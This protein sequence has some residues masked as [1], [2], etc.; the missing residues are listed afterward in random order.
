MWRDAALVGGKDLRVELRSRVT[1]TQ[2]AP[3]A[4]LVLLL[5]GFAFDQNHK[6]LTQAAPGLFWVAVLLCTLLAV[7]RSFALE[8]A[9]GARDGLRLS[10]LDPAGIFVGKAAAVAVQLAALEVLLGVGVVVLF[11]TSLH[12]PGLLILTAVAATVGLAAA[13]TLYGMMAAGLKVR[14]TLLPLLILP[15]VAPVLLGATQAWMAALGLSTTDGWKW[16]VLLVT[17]AAI[18]VTLG[19]L[20]FSTLVEEA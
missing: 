7:Q 15:V 4:V 8:A 14:E 3:Y 17:F 16:L 13:G 6:L 2:V 19:V 20:S 10:G 12:D 1:T 5:F 18:Y 11:G 9:D